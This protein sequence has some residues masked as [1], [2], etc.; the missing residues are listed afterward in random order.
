MTVTDPYDLL[1][2]PRD[3]TVAA[4][5]A[6]HR[7]LALRTHPDKVQD[8]SLRAAKQ[9]EFQRIQEA[10][11]ILSDESRRRQFDDER[12]YAAKRDL[13][14]SAAGAGSPSDGLSVRFEVRTAAPSKEFDRAY[15]QRRARRCADDD[16]PSYTIYEEKVTTRRHDG[17]DSRRPARPHDDRKPVRSKDDD[18]HERIRQDRERWQQRE[19]QSERRRTRERERRRGYDEKHA[20]VESV[21]EDVAPDER[22]RETRPYHITIEL[23]ERPRRKSDVRRREVRS[24]EELP[25]LPRRDARE[26]T[27]RRLSATN[28]DDAVGRK[29][30]VAREYMED[31]GTPRIQRAA[32][33]PHEPPAGVS[34]AA[35][36]AVRR[37]SARR[38]SERD[39]GR[40]RGLFGRAPASRKESSAKEPIEIVEPAYE[41]RGRPMPSLPTAVSSPSH[42][43][44]GPPMSS[45]PP[46]PPPRAST[47]QNP[48]ERERD[49]A[50]HE[51]PSLSRSSTMPVPGS[52][53]SSARRREPVAAS[54]AAAAATAQLR[55]G[56]VEVDS[57]YSSPNSTPD[58]APASGWKTTTSTTRQGAEYIVIDEG[59]R[60]GGGRRH[61]RP[62]RDE[63][64]HPSSGSDS[65]SDSDADHDDD[66]SRR[67]P[68]R[69]RSISPHTR[70]RWSE[71]PPPRPSP[72]RAATAAAA[73]APKTTSRRSPLGRSSVSYVYRP[74]KESSAHARTESNGAAAAGVSSGGSTRGGPSLARTGSAAHFSPSS[75][76]SS[77]ARRGP[78]AAYHQYSPRQVFYAE[79]IRPEHV[80]YVDTPRGGGGGSSSA[81]GVYRD[82][83]PH[84]SRSHYAH[85]PH[86]GFMR[87]ETSS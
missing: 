3:A 72:T 81:E 77:A 44:G 33:M 68:R 5:R 50:R 43:R 75:S 11:E 25:Q 71:H 1:G 21:E 51:H 40:G 12:K 52:A 76:S 15:E 59:Y 64:D 42:L 29:I 24:S 19:T 30:S 9:D 31:F 16:L 6:A 23:D 54:A 49:A 17:Y 27:R 60:Y 73:T 63:D 8:E 83:P 32:T 26:P 13:F 78:D 45:R 41:P 10:Y 28:H 20:R 57:G 66:R 69:D 34:L 53:G 70:G 4:I 58:P 37:S 82:V 61:R 14:A 65:D 80:T 7:K 87:A 35:D 79:R 22:E 84:H 67:D 86:P 62:V 46:A 55:T 2:V 74:S 85:G 36:D 47:M 39:R 18:E 56:R 48:R 38:P